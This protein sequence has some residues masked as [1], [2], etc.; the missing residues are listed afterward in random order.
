[1]N[2]ISIVIKEISCED[3]KSKFEDQ[4]SSRFNKWVIIDGLCIS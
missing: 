4:N 3:S 2:F 1:M